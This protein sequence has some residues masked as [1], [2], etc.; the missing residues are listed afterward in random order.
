MRA[1]VRVLATA[2]PMMLLTTALPA[3][4]RPASAGECATVVDERVF[5][6]EADLRQ[7]NATIAGFGLRTTASPAHR[8]MVDWLERQARRIP[9][10]TT[11]SEWFGIRRWLPLTGDLGSTGVLTV[12]GERV[13]VAG[14]VP[15]SR[16]TLGSTGELVYLPSGPIT[17]DNAR[18]KVVIRDFPAVDR[19]Y[20]AEGALNDDLV[21]AGLAGAAGLIVAFDFPREQ[22]RGY[23]D[24]H[25]GTHYRVPGVFVGV[26][27]ALRLKQMAGSRASVGVLAR[28]D[29]A[30]TR[31]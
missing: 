4:A 5:A 6:T 26:D 18:G 11:T 17:V 25:T 27:E 21:A 3:V 15:Y 1:T 28:T 22:V 13:P 7:L 23:Y 24:P 12:A 14:A 31:S 2:L 30:T 16:P 10:V 20:L 9:G 29:H 8:R 19:G